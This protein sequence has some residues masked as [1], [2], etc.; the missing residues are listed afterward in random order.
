MISRMFRTIVPFVVGLASLSPFAPGL[1]SAQTSSSQVANRLTQ[2]IDESSLV[3]IKGTVRPLANAVN[4]RGAAPDSMPLERIQVVLQRSPAQESALKQLIHDEHTAGTASYHKWLTPEQFGRRFGPSDQ[5]IATVESWLA[6][7]GFNVEKVNPGRQTLEMSGSVAQF[8]AAFHSQIHKYEVNGGTHYA[9]ASDPQIPAA[10]APVFGGFVSLNN[11][12]SKR[13][14]SVL[15]HA[16]YDPKTNNATPEWTYGS[17]PDFVLAPSDF[18]VQYDLPAASS[19]IN[20][21][22]QTIAIVNDSNIDISLVNAYRTLFNLPANPPQV[23]IDG[24]DPGVD[25]INDPGGPNFDSIEAYLDVEEAG[26]VAPSAT[27]DLVIGADTSLANG[28]ILAL[29]RAINSNI[30]PVMSI[31]FGFGCEAVLGTSNQFFSSLLEQAA[32]QG[33]TVM[34]ATGDNAAAACD[35][36]NTQYYAVGGAAVSGLAST[37]YGV[38]VG[39]TD[40][41]YSDYASGGASA[42]NYWNTASSQNPSTSLKA[43]IPEQPWNN[44]QFG[45]N[46]F[47]IYTDSGNTQTSI[48]GGSGGE[49]TVYAKPT[50]QAGNGVPAD[51]HRDLPDV[52]VFAATGLNASYYPICA[53]DGDCQPASGSNL[54]QI[55]GVGGTSASAPAFAGIMALVNQEYGRQGQADY[56]LYPLATQFPA[57]FH[58]VTHGTNSVPCKFSA[59]AASNTPDCISVTNPL[60]VSDPNL[61]PATEG[62]IGSGTTPEFNAT[63]GYD[64]STGLGTLDATQLIDYWN[65]VTF[66]S[67]SVSL[68]SPTT[69]TSIAHGSSV[70]FSGSVTP[71]GSSTPT[72]DVAIE[73]DSSEPGQQS[74]GFA[75]LSS[76][77]FSLSDTTLPGG[78]YNVWANYEGDGKN[79][80]APSQKAQITVTPENSSIYFAVNDV[81]TGRLNAGAAIISGG[82]A[83]YGTQLMLSAQV[84]PT[85]QFTAFQTCQTTSAACPAFTTPTGTVTFS[86]NGS[87]VNTAVINSNGDAEFNGG[88]AVNATGSHH[89]VTASYSGDSSYHSSTASPITFTITKDTPQMSAFSS[90]VTG[91]LPTG[92]SNVLT[93]Q[94]LNSANLTASFIETSPVAAPTGT[95]SISGLP[96]GSPTSATLTAGVD[97]QSGAPAGIATIVIPSSVSTGTYNVNVTYNG[98]ANY[99]TQTDALTIPAQSAGETPSTTTATISGSIS[100][101]TSVTISGTV[102]GKSGGAAP[103]NTGGGILI[104]SGGY[105][106]AEINVATG[107]GDSSTFAY[108]ANS[109]SLLQGSNTITVQYTGD[110]T[111]APSSV[112]LTTPIANPLSDFT[113]VPNTTIVPIAVGTGSTDIVHIASVNGF[114]G[115]VSLDCAAPSG[116]TCSVPSPA[117][118]T[119]GGSTT[120]TVTLNASSSAADGENNVRI[121]GTDSTGKFIH[122]LNLQAEVTGATTASPGFKL[123]AA[124]SISLAPGATTGNAVGVS[125]TPLNGFTG[126]VTL[127]ANTASGPTGA[128]S[129]PTVALTSDTLDITGQSALGTTLTITTTASTTPGNYTIQVT[130]MGGAD[131]EEAVITVTVTNA[132]FGLSASP[133]TLTLS[134]GAMTGNTS[135]ITVTPSGGFTGAVTFACAVT[136]APANANDPP[137]CAAPGATV[138]GSG[139]ATSTLTVSSTATTTTSVRHPLDEF[140][141]AGGGMVLAGL[142][143]FGIPAR[144]RSWRSILVILLFAGIAGLGIGCGSGGGGGGGG[145]G[146]TIPGTTPGAYV[147]TVTGTSGSVSQTTTVNLTVN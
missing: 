3:P 33:I 51:S 31:S 141:T 35:N 75:T 22:G 99:T 71:T 65:S 135:T 32:A 59:S 12:R 56:V 131:S 146:K 92:Q 86:D 42:S 114:S 1:L 25:G 78:T 108:T 38:A 27:I 98:D 15:G 63:A 45:L 79:A 111:Y 46:I 110:N 52:S 11:F 112:T 70:T 85:A 132:N 10:L 113:M 74:Q 72:G 121:T 6:S 142:L 4:D 68:T 116:V 34:V 130:G 47:S 103:S 90:V 124:P 64:L 84:A 54:V 40:F 43:V 8:R 60:N 119:S 17:G 145:G 136:T 127:S 21:S 105:Y 107:S 102:T 77:A 67:T 80:S 87:P 36:D 134:A 28:V 101:T 16:S 91:F 140:F 115:A 55:T 144:K 97:P 73:T 93:I 66:G 26:A 41:F 5:D 88:W 20:G 104:Y 96:S 129:P 83:P 123:L 19:G 44:S 128:T 29:Q 48:A 138:S 39:G 125:V 143:L 82:S 100:P 58:D 117:T 139:T 53:A 37:P 18:A 118:L 81:A 122:T 147:L 76:G 95:V 126:T 7:K 24:N 50:W 49:S 69:G 23:I 30:A 62:Q 57:A 2:P 14:S 89:S 61:G 9:N 13:M 120:A 106:I 109:R 94:I 133:A 137:T